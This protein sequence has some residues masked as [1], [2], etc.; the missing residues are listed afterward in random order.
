MV[1]SGIK[2][3]WIPH[4]RFA[5]GGPVQIFSGRSPTQNPTQQE[6]GNRS[7]EGEI[8]WLVV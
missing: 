8:R 2:A 5:I 6:W 1:R 3:L 4:S 7:Q